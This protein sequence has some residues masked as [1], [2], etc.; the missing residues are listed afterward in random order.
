MQRGRLREHFQLNVDMVGE[1]H[2][3]ADAEVLAVALDSLRLLGL[4]EQDIVARVNDRRLL[5]KLLLA[6]GVESAALVPVYNVIDKLGRDTREES[7]RRLQQEAGL[8]ADTIERVFALFDYANLDAIAEAFVHDAPTQE[9]IARMRDYLASVAEL[10]LADYVAFDPTIVRGLAYYTGFVF[11]IF[12]RQGELRAIC[13]GG[14]YDALL[15]TVSEVDLPALGFGMGDVVLTELL[16]DRNL[17]PEKPAGIDYYVV[18]ISEQEQPLQRRI[19]H[20]LRE[21]GYAVSHGFGKSGVGK[22]FKDADARNAR[23]AIVLGPSEIAEGIVVVRDMST[24]SEQRIPLERA[25]AGDLGMV[26]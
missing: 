7:T 4:T 2:V 3:A 13:G 14:R 1:A 16:R 18:T 20:A 15:R 23:A 19:A 22:Q 12:D 8:D 21:Q 9:A 11:E 24:G 26:E 25:L 6:S 17:L 10:G 5:E